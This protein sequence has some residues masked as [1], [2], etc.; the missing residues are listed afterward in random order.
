MARQSRAHRALVVTVDISVEQAHCDRLDALNEEPFGHGRDLVVS[1]REVDAAVGQHP[2]RDAVGVSA[3]DQ[4]LSIFD[5]R[6]EH[7]VAMLVADIED[8]AEP[9]G[10]QERGLGTSALNDGVGD[11][12]RCM[13]D[14]VID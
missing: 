2:L 12:G 4:R 7:V 9:F 5:L 11:H 8:V 1:Y 13:D 3:R 6:I 10:D 14:H